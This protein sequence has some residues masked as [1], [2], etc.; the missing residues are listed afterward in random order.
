M[1]CLRQLFRPRH[2]PVVCLLAKRKICRE[3]TFSFLRYGQYSAQLAC[4]NA[5][6]FVSMVAGGMFLGRP[7][8]VTAC[9]SYSRF[10]C[11]GVV[12]G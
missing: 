8:L 11:D 7:I 4:R 9:L 12:I 1:G 6:Y 2:V 10:A 5:W 3:I